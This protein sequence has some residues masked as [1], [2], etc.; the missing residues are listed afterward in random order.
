MKFTRTLSILLALILLCCSGCSR[1][2]FGY[3]HADWILRYWING[4]TSFNAQQKEEIRL[5]V[6]D[7]MRWHRQ[8]ALPKYIAFLQTLDTLAAQDRALSSRDAIHVRAELSRLYKLTMT[9]FILP[10]AH[11]LSTLDD[12]QIEEL[13]HTLAERNREEK[14]EALAGG[15]QER[16]VTRAQRT[17]HFVESLVGHVSHEQEQK[18]QKMSLRMPYVT[19]SYFEQREAKQAAL[20]ALLSKHAGEDRIA[21]FFWQWINTPPVTASPQQQHTI[22]AYDNA[23]N[24]MIVGI[25]DLLTA[26]QKEH[27]REK[28]ATYID[29]FK[30][31]ESSSRTIVLHAPSTPQSDRSPH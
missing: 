5:E 20:I 6:A 26:K 29:A 13:R 8:H 27:L 25:F 2:T 31:L 24:E 10:A 22:E 18:I 3:N 19:T 14:E 17:V 15:E 4:Y 28:I 16:L 11:L 7:Y 23:V 21:A 9:P 30:K 12:S 1:I